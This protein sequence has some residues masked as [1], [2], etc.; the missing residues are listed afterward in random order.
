MALTFTLVPGVTL[1]ESGTVTITPAILN[2]M[3]S[4]GYVS[5]TSG[6]LEAGNYGAGSIALAD[7]AAAS[8][9]GTIA[10]V[11]ADDNV[12]G[13]LGLI[14]RIDIANSTADTDVVLT[15]KTRIVDYWGYKTGANGGAGD[16]VQI[17]N[18]TNIISESFDLSSTNDKK[19]FQFTEIDDVYHEI[20]AS[21]TLRVSAN[22]STNCACT[23][24]VLGVRV[25]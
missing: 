9:D 12:I 14:H 15:H 23:I 1:S 6:Q 17:K 8:L 16:T 10:K 18:S 4:E 5:A 22:S 25:S 13:G 19:R 11:V 7:I 20:A 3:F 24:Y 21:G 2:R